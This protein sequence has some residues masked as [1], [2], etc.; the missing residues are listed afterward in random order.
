MGGRSVSLS[1]P[2]G[3]GS[4]VSPS[5]AASMRRKSLG[6]PLRSRTSA[7]CA[8]RLMSSLYATAQARLELLPTHGGARIVGVFLQFSLH[9]ENINLVFVLL[10]DGAA[11]HLGHSYA[12]L[13]RDFS[14]GLMKVVRQMNQ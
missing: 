13:M 10:L 7:R 2:L 3:R 1:A 8:A 6:C 12:L 9:E 14:D 4:S 11:N 5:I